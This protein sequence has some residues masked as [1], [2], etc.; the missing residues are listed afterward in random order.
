MVEYDSPL[1]SIRITR[2]RRAA[3]L[4][5]METGIADLK[6]FAG[7]VQMLDRVAPVNPGQNLEAHTIF[8]QELAAE[9]QAAALLPEAEAAGGVA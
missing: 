5:E 1:A 8:E 7:R 9:T 2:A 3:E 4:D 6:R